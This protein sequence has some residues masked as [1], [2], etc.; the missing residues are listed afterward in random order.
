MKSI[1]YIVLFS[2]C[3]SFN[4]SAQNYST[5]IMED[6]AVGSWKNTMKFSNTFDTN[7]N[8]LTST[9]EMWNDAITNWDKYMLTTNS[10]NPD[11]TI[12]YSISQSWNTDGNAWENAQ[13]TIYTYDNSKRV[14]T[15][16]N[17]ISVLTDWMDFSTV[18][19]TYNGNGQ[20]HTMVNKN[21]NPMNM[22]MKN[23][24]QTTYTYNPDGTENQT[25]FQQWADG[26]GT[27]ENTMRMTNS[28]NASKVILSV[29]TENFSS[30]EWVNTI[31]AI[32]SYNTDGTLK[33][34]LEQKWN[35][36]ESKWVDS[37]KESYTYF[38]NGKVK[39]MVSTKWLAD[40]SLWENDGRITY[41]YNGLSFIQS[42]LAENQL[43]VFPNPFTENIS[44]IGKSIEEY[45]VQLFNANGQLVRSFEKGQAL[46]EINLASLKNGYYF[47]Q[48]VSPKSQQVIKLI[49]S[50]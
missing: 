25:V 28:Y 50:K 8:I 43:I 24:T 41:T 44:I 1:I 36:S 22:Q 23:F 7:G 21:L 20:L 19:Y 38:T 9:I 27:W 2:L 31:K 15:E 35:T 29:L 12:N 39:Q 32:N 42:N 49:K 16:K 4:L 10:L 37:G 14:L 34:S 33:E 45:N 6:Y 13:K 47:I 48:A 11:G 5:M 26:S 46:N 30:G 3:F 40:Q 18:T 17:Q